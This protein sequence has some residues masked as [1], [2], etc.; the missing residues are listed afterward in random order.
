MATAGTAALT[1]AETTLFES[2]DGC[3][4]FSVS[5]S[6]SSSGDVLVNVPTLHDAGEWFVLEPGETAVF[7]LNDLGI[8]KVLAKSDS[9]AT[10]NYGIVART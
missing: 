7:R 6:S 8:R 2:S 1:T 3:T 4:T 9:T 10:A 5:N